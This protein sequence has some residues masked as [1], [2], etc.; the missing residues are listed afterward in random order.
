[1]WVTVRH[2]FVTIHEWTALIFM[3]TIV[4]HIF[5]HWTYVKSNLKKH[6]IMK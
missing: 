2:F 3:I 6:G 4:I 5:L 1:V